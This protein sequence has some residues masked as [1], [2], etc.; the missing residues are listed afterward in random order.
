LE[1][2]EQR[3]EDAFQALVGKF[4]KMPKSVAIARV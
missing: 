4:T 1:E 3:G 2:K